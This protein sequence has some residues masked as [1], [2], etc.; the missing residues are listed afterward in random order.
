[1]PNCF[2]EGDWGQ[3]HLADIWLGACESDFVPSRKP[4][5][6]SAL[7]RPFSLNE[8]E[9]KPCFWGNEADLVTELDEVPKHSVFLHMC[10]NPIEG[11]S[12]PKIGWKMFSLGIQQ[13]QLLQLGFPFLVALFVPYGPQTWWWYAQNTH[14]ALYFIRAVM[15]TQ[16][17]THSPDM[18][19]HRPESEELPWL[20]IILY[21]IHCQRSVPGQE[22]VCPL[23]NEVETKV[24]EVKVVDERVACPTFI[25]GRSLPLVTGCWQK[26]SLR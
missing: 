22:V 12:S 10:L 19:S 9:S 14:T 24:V 18:R 2:F 11:V 7:Y 8:P 17:C 1:M 4:W 13:L 21:L 15:N 3:L 6:W 23:C 25:Q 16:R 5:A 26:K 20:W